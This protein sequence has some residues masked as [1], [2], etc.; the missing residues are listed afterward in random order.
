[1]QSFENSTQAD[2]TGEDKG[3]EAAKAEVS[4]TRVRSGRLNNQS[5]KKDGA[6]L[7]I[8]EVAE[9]L[10]VQQHVLRFWETKFAHVRPLKRGGG[11]RYYRPEDVE[12]LQKI[13][14]LLYT[15]GYTIKGVQ[16]MLREKGKKE[17]MQTVLPEPGNGND[18]AGAA[19]QTQPV[20]AAPVSAGAAGEG[21]AAG[22]L[23]DRQKQALSD[24]LSELRAL[25][26]LVASED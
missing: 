13:Q 20:A 4:V 8:S 26:S 23:N 14:Y 21:Q 15:E 9:L 1:M 17:L 22:G 11:R 25:R 18:A 7:T 2:G 19:P 10:N 24:M 16:K 6:F 5:E 3:N 12:L